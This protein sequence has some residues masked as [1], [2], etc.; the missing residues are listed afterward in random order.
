M[1]AALADEDDALGGARSPRGDRVGGE[2]L[3]E[4]L[5]HRDGAAGAALW[6]VGHAEGPV[7][8]DVQRRAGEVDVGPF[9]GERL[10]ESQTGERERE[11]EAAVTGVGG[12]DDGLDLLGREVLIAAQRVVLASKR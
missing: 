10:A 5:G 11:E 1:H 2:G 9:E 4:L 6:R 12:A 8:L 3:G 7:A